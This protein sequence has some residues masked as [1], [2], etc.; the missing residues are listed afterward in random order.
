MEV[1][2]STKVESSV[3]GR[4]KEQVF[5]NTKGLATLTKRKSSTVR[6]IE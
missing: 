2:E 4:K 3:K 5:D 1:R 6:R